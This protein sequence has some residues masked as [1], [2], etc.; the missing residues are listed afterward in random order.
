VGP[1]TASTAFQ[2]ACTI[3]V[4]QEHLAGRVLHWGTEPQDPPARW[5]LEPADAEKLVLGALIKLGGAHRWIALTDLVDELAGLQ[6]AFDP[7]VYRRRN[8]PEL[9]AS[10]TSVEVDGEPIQPYVRIA[11]MRRNGSSHGGTSKS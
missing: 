6:P 8:M 2:N 4:Q 7:R 3:F 5:S 1:K 10:L 9:L 11:L